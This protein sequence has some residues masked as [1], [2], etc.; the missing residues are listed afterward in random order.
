VRL[1]EADHVNFT[2]DSV[3]PR[4]AAVTEFAPFNV[5][6]ATS[7]DKKSS[8]EDAALKVGKGCTDNGS[9]GFAIGWGMAAFPRSPL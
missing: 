7:D 3:T 4:E 8:L 1:N 6:L 5:D 2:G 9:A